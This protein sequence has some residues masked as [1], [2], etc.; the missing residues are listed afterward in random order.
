MVSLITLSDILV[1]AFGKNTGYRPKMNLNCYVKHLV[2]DT[3]KDT[4]E[5]LA[6]KPEVSA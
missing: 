4:S 1:A 6:G 5:T 3:R 2:N